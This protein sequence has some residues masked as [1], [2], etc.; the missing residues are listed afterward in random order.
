M[1]VLSACAERTFYRFGIFVDG[2][3]Y[4]CHGLRHQRVLGCSKGWAR[5]EFFAV[6]NGLSPEVSRYGPEL[7]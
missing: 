4:S 3:L 6:T 5:L 1:F 7:Q 2:V